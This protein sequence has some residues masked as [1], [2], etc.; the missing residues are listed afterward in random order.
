MYFICSSVCRS[1]KE[2]SNR[3]AVGNNCLYMPAVT[4]I[5]VQFGTMYR[6]DWAVPPMRGRSEISGD[7]FD[8]DRSGVPVCSPGLVFCNTCLDELR[9]ERGRNRLVGWKANGGFVELVVV[10]LG[11]VRTQHL[12][13]YDVE[14]TVSLERSEGYEHSLMLKSRDLIA[15]AFSSFG[16]RSLD[17]FAELLKR[18]PGILREFSEVAVNGL[19]SRN[20]FGAFYC[21][22]LHR[23]ILSVLLGPSIG[24]SRGRWDL[25]ATPSEVQGLRSLAGP[26]QCLFLPSG[27]VLRCPW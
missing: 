13:A 22:S 8:E 1:N 6:S 18:G 14:T 4:S 9:H 11:G 21:H 15:N 5:A 7:A 3:Q 26:R 12:L 10:E 17:C 2:S 20:S 27:F 19:C 23:T 25:E 24:F 16:R